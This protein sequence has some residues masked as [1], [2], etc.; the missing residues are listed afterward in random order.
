MSHKDIK[1]LYTKNYRKRKKLFIGSLQRETKKLFTE[2][3][4]K[5]YGEVTKRET[6]KLYRNKQ[7]IES[8]YK[9]TNAIIEGLQRVTKKL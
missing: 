8:G 1:K 4:K 6:K 2:R 5:L 9:K 3:D 7:A